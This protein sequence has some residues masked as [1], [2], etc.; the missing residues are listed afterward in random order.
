MLFL[1]MSR[2][3]ESYRMPEQDKFSETFS[4]EITLA[5]PTHCLLEFSQD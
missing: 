1:N 3:A 2:E 5:A 4:L